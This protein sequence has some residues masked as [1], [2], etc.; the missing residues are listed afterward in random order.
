[1]L[2]E[3]ILNNWPFD[4]DLDERPGERGDEEG[5][6]RDDTAGELEDRLG[7]VRAHE[8]GAELVLTR[9]PRYGDGPPL[10]MLRFHRE[11]HL[12][13]IFPRATHHGRLEREFEQVTELQLEDFNWDADDHSAEHDRFGLLYVRGLPKGFGSIYEFGLGIQREYADLIDEI[14]KHTECTIVRFVD[15][16]PEGEGSDGKTFRLSL[17][18]FEN[19]RATV[20]LNRGRGRTA[21]RRVVEAECHNAVAALFGL[22][23]VQ[24]K[25]GR[26]AVIR[27]LTEEVATGH[28]MDP[29]DRDLLASELA[30]A[31]PALAREAPERL[32]QLRAD[33]E[34]VS[35]EALIERFTM[36]L[37]GRHATDEPYWQDFFNTNRFAL[38]QVFSTPLVV[39]REHAHVQAADVDGRGA[40][41]TDFLCANT[42]TRTAIVVEIKTPAAKL[43][44]D[45][46]YRGRAG[47]AAVY[48]PHLHLSG[49]VSQVQSQLAA[50]PQDLAQRLDRTPELDID[51]WHDPRGAVI[52]GRLSSLDGARRESFLRYRAGL[53]VVTVLGYDEILEHLIALHRMLQAAPQDD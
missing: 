37:A 6:D 7:W 48:P 29:E 19:Y 23:R 13:R 15:S 35:L 49:A 18:R 45:R 24:P 11:H 39:L 16:D 52:A 14:E 38:Q 5:R 3:A 46:P 9:V 22:E 8:D 2:R 21:V 47:S 33:I 25:F 32:G 43:V 42:V 10:E 40:R 34:L 31:A 27:A 12:L 30:R 26:N 50:V 53:S 1:M 20:N 41:I 36:S 4:D 44:T 51:A 28:V 17:R